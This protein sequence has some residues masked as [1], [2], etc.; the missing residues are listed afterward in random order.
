MI[1]VT[2]ARRHVRCGLRSPLT[3][4]VAKLAVGRQPA[5]NVSEWRTIT[6]YAGWTGHAADN[7]AQLTDSTTALYVSF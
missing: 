4:V 1:A 6:H 7:A 3:E 2:I 5:L